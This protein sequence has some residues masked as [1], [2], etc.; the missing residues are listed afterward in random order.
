MR[1]IAS[2]NYGQPATE[3]GHQ[4]HAD[5]RAWHGPVEAAT[6]K[7]WRSPPRPEFWR[8]RPA[9]CSCKFLMK[10]ELDSISLRLERSLTDRTVPY[11]TVQYRSVLMGMV[12]ISFQFWKGNQRRFRDLILPLDT[13]TRSL[14]VSSGRLLDSWQLQS[15]GGC[16][17]DTIKPVSTCLHHQC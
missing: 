15:T 5:A 8:R 7:I 10:F 16:T 12:A 6:C 3:P 2:A 1:R 13:H 14:S 11:S 9:P 17:R 4:G